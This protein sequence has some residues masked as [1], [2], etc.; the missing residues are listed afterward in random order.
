M[1][2]S[3]EERRFQLPDGIGGVIDVSGTELFENYVRSQA[4]VHEAM[5]NL[6]KAGNLYYPADPILAKMEETLPKEEFLAVA[7]RAMREGQTDYIRMQ[8]LPLGEKVHL[9]AIRS[10]A[11]ALLAL[12]DEVQS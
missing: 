6:L 11:D 10:I 4:E 1:S 7:E 9:P 3:P 5:V 12:A 8:L 2:S